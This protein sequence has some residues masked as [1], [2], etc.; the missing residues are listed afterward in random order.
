MRHASFLVIHLYRYHHAHHH[1][2]FPFTLI[3]TGE[4]GDLKH[5][6]W[7]GNCGDAASYFWFEKIACGSTRTFDTE[8]SLM[9]DFV[10]LTPTWEDQQAILDIYYTTKAPLSAGGSGNVGFVFIDEGFSIP[11]VLPPKLECKCVAAMDA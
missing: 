7:A 3:P 1:Y 2:P 5:A 10:M 8:R 4:K 6:N 9:T 11:P